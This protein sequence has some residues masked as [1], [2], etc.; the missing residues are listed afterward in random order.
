MYADFHSCC[1]WKDCDCVV[2]TGADGTCEPGQHV[3]DIRS[4][5]AIRSGCVA[6]LDAFQAHDAAIGE[7]A[8]LDLPGLCPF[9][10]PLPLFGTSS[11]LPNK[12]SS[13][14]DRYSISYVY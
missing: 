13:W 5:A 12:V 8:A 7:A 11:F 3:F 14:K 10:G 1:R 9:D 6:V 2:K 4:L